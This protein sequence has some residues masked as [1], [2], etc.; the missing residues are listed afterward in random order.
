MLQIFKSAGFNKIKNKI[1]D[2]VFNENKS[3]KTH[4]NPHRYRNLS[5]SNSRIWIAE[6]ER[7]AEEV[8][9]AEK[10]VVGGEVSPGKECAGKEGCHGLL[11]LTVPWSEL[12]QT[13]GCCCMVEARQRRVAAPAHF[14]AL[15]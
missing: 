1:I 8:V 2:P 13:V 12:N 9:G 6:V 15:A 4:L 7:V 14:H 11:Q 10:G 3:A 5:S